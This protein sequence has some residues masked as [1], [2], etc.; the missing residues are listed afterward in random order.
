MKY[1]IYLF[2][3]F[4]ILNL[5]AQPG[6]LDQSF[7]ISGIALGIFPTDYN[8]G[9]GVYQQSDGKLLNVGTISMAASTDDFYTVYLM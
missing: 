3:F 4:I 9:Y 1:L 6:A 7:G 8:S 5:Q 2:P